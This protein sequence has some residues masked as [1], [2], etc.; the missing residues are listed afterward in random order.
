M[1]GKLETAMDYETVETIAKTFDG[2][3]DIFRTA[4]K[5]L[6]AAIIIL[7]ATAFISLGATEALAAYLSNIK[8]HVEKL[9]NQPEELNRDL[10]NAIKE[11]RE[12][13]QAAAGKFKG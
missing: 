11:H 9:G 6:E 1:A 5:A 7:K 2:M 13:D 10:L 12:A 8:P 4:A 3:G